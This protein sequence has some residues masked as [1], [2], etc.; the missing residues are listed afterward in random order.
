MTILTSLLGRRSA[1]PMERYARIVV[2]AVLVAMAVDEIFYAV[3]DWPLHDMDVY[4]GAAM[5]LRTGQPL[6]VPGDVA[7]DSFWY[8]PWFAVAWIP[9]TVLPRLVVAVLWS[10]TLLAAS[11][12]VTVMLARMDRNGPMLA[13]LVGPLLFAVSAG[14]NIQALMVLS[15][16]WGFNRGSGPLWVAIAAS[17]KYTPILLA[18][19]YVARREWFKAISAGLLAA[20]LIG[21]GFV[22]GLANAGVRSQAAA[23]LLGSS[24]PTYLILVV[25]FALLAL[26]GP[27][28]YS[29]LASSAAAV[30]ALPRLFAYDVT[31][32]ATG[33]SETKA[34]GSNR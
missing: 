12:A 32:I 8:A 17:M 26:A 22:L 7:V 27:R 5:R 14:G 18:L 23:S 21:P 6:Y 11:A 3:K 34:D 31:L 9:L 19:T 20:A 4:L 33:A 25:A 30:L 24:L 1:S 10:A 15:L 16:L 29:T 28:R 13:L 2:V